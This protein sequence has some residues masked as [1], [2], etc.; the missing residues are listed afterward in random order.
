MPRL[1]RAARG[2]SPSCGC[3]PR[4]RRAGTT[5]PIQRTPH[6]DVPK[7]RLS[8]LHEASQVL[9]PGASLGDDNPSLAAAEDGGVRPDHKPCDGVMRGADA[10]DRAAR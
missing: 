10:P 2:M 8:R 4:T 5:Y 3:L 9:S 7:E 1:I 6:R